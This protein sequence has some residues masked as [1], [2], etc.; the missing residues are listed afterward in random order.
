MT[1]RDDSRQEADVGQ[2]GDIIDITVKKESGD[3]LIVRNL[4]EDIVRALKLRAAL[5]GRSAEAEHRE[6]LR[7]ALLPARPRD[8]KDLLLAIP[9]VGEDSDFERETDFG[10]DVDL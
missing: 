10:R 9:P 4:E 6:I 7:E 2:N 8:L 1:V 5:H 3:Q